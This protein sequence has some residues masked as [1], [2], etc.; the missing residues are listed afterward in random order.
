MSFNL[1]DSITMINKAQRRVKIVG[2]LSV[3]GEDPSTP[4]MRPLQAQTHL[5]GL[6]ELKPANSL[7]CGAVKQMLGNNL[8]SFLS[9]SDLEM[10]PG[11][12]C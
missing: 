4:L 5:N 11:F 10:L 8:R 7:Q 2:P 12:T 1:S 3:F 9:S 6:E